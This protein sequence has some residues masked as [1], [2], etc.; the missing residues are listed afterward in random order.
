MFIH[1]I[2]IIIL[3]QHNN[4][5]LRTNMAVKCEKFVKSSKIFIDICEKRKTKYDCQT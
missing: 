3:P 1:Y 2:N 5:I 4:I